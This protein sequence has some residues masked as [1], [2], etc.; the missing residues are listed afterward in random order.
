MEQ[1]TKKKH[2]HHGEIMGEFKKIKPLIFNG[3]IE[4]GVEAKAWISGM[5]KH[6]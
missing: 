4:S 1:R 5:K 2:K 3:E 6:F